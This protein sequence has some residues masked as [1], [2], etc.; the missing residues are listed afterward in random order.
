M[1]DVG[2]GRRDHTAKSVVVQGP[3][4]VFPGRPATEVLA[5]DQDFGVLIVGV[6]EDEIRMRLARVWSLL[7]APPV[8]EQKRSIAS[9][10][11]P[12]QELLGDDLVSID[13]LAVQVCDHTLMFAEWLHGSDTSGVGTGLNC[14]LR[15]SVKC[16]ETAAAA[17]IMGL[18]RWV[19]PPR[20]W[21]PSKLRLLVEAQRSPGARISGFMPRH[22]EQPGPRPSKP[23]A[24]N[25][26][27][28]PSSSACFFT[29]CEPGTTI[30]R[31]WG[32][33]WYPLTTLAAERRSSMRALVHEPMKTRSIASSSM[34]LPGS[35]AMYSSARSQARRSASEWLEAGSG[36]RSVTCTTIPGLV[37]QVTKGARSSAWST[38]SRSKLAPA[39]VGS[40][41]HSAT[42]R[43]QSAPMGLNRRPLR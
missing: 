22:M 43:S 23:A 15:T 20:P 12:L 11:D 26:S 42:A 18:T 2:E 37:P 30:A 24:R 38:S 39:S 14:H 33:T 7:N 1:K 9:A 40:D 25:T 3:S 41:R 6:I 17:A 8:V 35:S 27:S 31:T 29:C 21:R 19:R 34:A 10:L 5:R 16:P 4:G 13:V 32:C 36:T 28:S